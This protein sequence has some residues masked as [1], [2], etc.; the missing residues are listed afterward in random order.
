MA[1]LVIAA[2]EMQVHVVRGRERMRMRVVF[3]LPVK[4]E[5]R[6][7]P[8][9]RLFLHSQNPNTHMRKSWA[10][11]KITAACGSDDNSAV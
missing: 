5:L 1:A 2:R 11:L 7:G 8:S 3:E 6:E 10:V 4:R 9:R